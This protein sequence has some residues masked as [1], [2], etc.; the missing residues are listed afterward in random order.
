MYFYNWCI[1]LY[2]LD[3]SQ[4]YKEYVPQDIDIYVKTSYNKYSCSRG[5][6]GTLYLQSAIAGVILR[7]GRQL[8]KLPLD[9]G[10]EAWVLRDGNL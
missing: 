3:V 10:V 5:A 8:V 9:R 7:R 6:S 2:I 1:F 4:N